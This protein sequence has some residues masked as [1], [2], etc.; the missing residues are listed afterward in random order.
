MRYKGRSVTASTRV[1]R[2]RHMGFLLSCVAAFAMATSLRADQVE[3]RNGDRS[4]GKV[5]AL[6]ANTL[7]VK[8]EVLGVVR[9]PREKVSAII[10]GAAPAAPRPVAAAGPSVS[11]KA[12]APLDPA[13]NAANPFRE[14]AAHT[15]LIHK[16]QSQ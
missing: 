2:M 6:N 11:G 8:N 16:I 14:L 4:V 1:R 15:N 3:M 10:L 5:V 7:V 12:G 13:A 9:I